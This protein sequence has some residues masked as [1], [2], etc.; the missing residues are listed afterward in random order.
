MVMVVTRM[1][2][3]VKSDDSLN[4]CRI[5]WLIVTFNHRH[6]ETFNLVGVSC[7]AYSK[8]S[9]ECHNPLCVAPTTSGMIIGA[10]KIKL[11]DALFAC[12]L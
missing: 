5:E 11:F 8:G 12:S 2:T 10:F 3:F 4:M 1:F 7:K 9:G 6:L